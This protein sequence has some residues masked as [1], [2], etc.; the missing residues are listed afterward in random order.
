[1]TFADQYI[2]ERVTKNTFLHQINLLIRW[3]DLRSVLN[4]YKDQLRQPKGRKSYDPIVLFKMCLLQ[5]WYN[6]SD[7]QVEEQVNDSL[8]F[9]RFCGLSLEDG[10]PDHST[11]CR[12]RNALT[13][14]KV[15][16]QLL[17]G[18]NDQL[19]QAQILVKQG[20]IVDASITPSPRKPKG[21]KVYKLE[22]DQENE[23]VE[24]QFKKGVDQQARWTK[25][26]G[27]AHFGYKQHIATEDQEGLILSVTTTSANRHDITEFEVVV[28]KAK[29]PKY[30]KL[31]ADKGYAGSEKSTTL[32]QKDYLPR[33]QHRATRNHPLTDRQIQANKIISKTRYKVERAFGSM[34]RW[35]GFR[36]ARYVG[37]DKM[38]GQ[39]VINAIAYNLRRSPGIIV[40]NAL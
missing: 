25:K 11:L 14:K 36:E 38:H 35:F 15:W 4:Q 23:K 8:S 21:K 12:F 5:T 27:K 19:E 2:A 29:L 40:S 16:D 7:R 1:M 28:D 31:Y 3:Q 30:A 33:V 17:D 18:I 37:L 24:Q 26:G 10:V 32:R 22:V 39:H 34:R 20:A 9:M 6:L 13:Q